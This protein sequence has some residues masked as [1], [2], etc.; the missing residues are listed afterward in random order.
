MSRSRLSRRG[1][2]TGLG[3]LALSLPLMEAL[4]S[5]LRWVGAAHAGEGI[6]KRFVIF[7]TPNGTVPDAWHPTGTETNFTLSR[8]LEPL[9]PV[10]KDILVIDGLD[11]LSA[12]NGPGDAHQRATGQC[13][14]GTELQ[15]GAFQGA[16]GRSAGWANG[17]SI[18]QAIANH[19]GQE[20]RFRSLELG[21]YVSGANVNSRI[22]YTGPAQPLPP[23][24]DPSAVFNRLF[25]TTPQ[26]PTQELERIARR[27]SVL[28]SVSQRYK[29]LLPRVSGADRIKLEAHLA[30]IREI[31][32][33]L[34]AGTGRVCAPPGKPGV[35]DPKEIDNVPALGKLQMDLLVAA[36]SCDLTRVASLMWMNSATDKTYPWLGVHEA[37]HE[38]AHAGDSDLHAKESLTKIYRWY[39]EQFAYLV[40]KLGSVPEG[41]GTL[42]DHT[43]VLWVSE[44]SK[45]NS[46]DRRQLP[47]VAAGRAGGQVRSGRLLKLNGEVPHN[48]L[49]TSCLNLFGVE[50]QTFGNPAYCTGPLSGLS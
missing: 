2:L 6:P 18:D 24:N 4:P 20:T 49:W 36:L 9:A 41:N 19:I 15:E 48:N 5:P 16:S 33:R 39:A 17:I 3:G 42:L 44:H 1:F 37:H 29:A 46:H 26:T 47:Y 32:Q 35:M 22:S 40:A 43:L 8:I 14:T 38:L 21:V 27:R 7:W 10:K 45:G 25:S 50:A 23:E 30:S 31:E 13:L 34:D 12:Y 11:A 28:D